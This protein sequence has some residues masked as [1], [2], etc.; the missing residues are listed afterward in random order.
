QLGRGGMSTVYLAEHQLMKRR[1]AIKVLPRQRVDDRSYLGRFLREAQATAA[2]D[3]P[4]IV[5]VYDIAAEGKIHFIAMEYVEGK[6][7]QTLVADEGPLDFYR[8]AD[9]IAQA[10]VGL[11]HAHD[12]G[13]THRDVKP[14]NLMANPEGIVKV[15][16]LGLARF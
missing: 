8:A 10:A 9:Y 11:Q 16:D 2:L 5:R 13:L 1:A 12:Q 3:H 4:N 15:L 14:A 6:D 7:L